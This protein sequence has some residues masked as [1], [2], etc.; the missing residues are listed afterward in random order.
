[1]DDDSERNLED[2]EDAVMETPEDSPHLECWE[3]AERKA[4]EE[5]DE[6]LEEQEALLESFATARKE[7]RT[8]TAAAQ[9]VR[10]K[11]SLRGHGRIPACPQFPVGR[12]AEVACIWKA[13]AERR[14]VFEGDASCSTNGEGVVAAVISSDEKE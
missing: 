14:K 13:A 11:S 1:L 12:F 10:A 3:E 2:D 7:E 5:E 6:I 8:H 9:A 4:E